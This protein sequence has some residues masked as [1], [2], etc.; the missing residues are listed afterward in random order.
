MRNFTVDE[1]FLSIFESSV[2]KKF[3]KL[4]KLGASG[5]DWEKKM[6]M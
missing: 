3:E 1:G 6:N 4:G 5:S 2:F